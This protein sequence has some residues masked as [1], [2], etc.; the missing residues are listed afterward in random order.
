MN[1]LFSSIKSGLK[2]W[3]PATG[4]QSQTP[5][6]WFTEI[7]AKRSW[8]G[9]TEQM[10]FH[11]LFS[12]A[13]SPWLDTSASRKKS[14][15]VDRDTVLATLDC[16]VNQKCLGRIFNMTSPNSYL[17]YF[18]RFCWKKK[19]RVRD[20]YIVLPGSFRSNRLLNSSAKLFVWF[21]KM[22]PVTSMV[23][24]RFFR[25]LFETSVAMPFYTLLKIA[26]IFICL[27]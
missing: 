23:V 19:E 6:S 4:V 26:V 25:R 21:T 5:C 20:I 15:D 3:C 11:F 12:P 22:P 14:T 27:L 8:A 9:F 17:F 24:H 13:L 10:L 16:S 7:S 1:L 2:C 18:W